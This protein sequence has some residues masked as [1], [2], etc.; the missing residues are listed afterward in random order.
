MGRGVL[1]RGRAAVAGDG[2][3]V[4]VGEDGGEPLGDLVE[5]DVGGDLVEPTARPTAQR[6]AQPLG[7]VVLITE[8]A[9]LDARVTAEERIGQIASNRTDGR[10]RNDDQL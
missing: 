8:V 7:M 1:E 10:R 6:G 3:T 2:A 4:T 5:G 9:A